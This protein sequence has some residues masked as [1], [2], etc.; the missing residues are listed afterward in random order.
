MK[1]V[2]LYIQLVL[3]GEKAMEKQ[4]ERYLSA[5]FSVLKANIWSPTDEVM[6]EVTQHISFCKSREVDVNKLLSCVILTL[7]KH[8]FV[9]QNK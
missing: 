8:A 9:F 5:L 4:M 6:P 1:Q 2:N 7:F 3:W